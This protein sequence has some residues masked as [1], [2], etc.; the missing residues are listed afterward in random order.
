MKVF[1]KCIVGSMV[2]TLLYFLVSLLIYIIAYKEFGFRNE[3]PFDDDINVA[4]GYGLS[5]SILF[6]FVMLIA[7]LISWRY[8]KTI[9]ITKIILLSFIVAIVFTLYDRIIIMNFQEHM[10]SMI[11]TLT[12]SPILILVIA[13]L[14]ARKYAHAS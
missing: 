13:I 10:W 6:L 11:A 8:V 2:G 7:F 5:M 14:G 4:F 9:R 12:G 1:A 3:F